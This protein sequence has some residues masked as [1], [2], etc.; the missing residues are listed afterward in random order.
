MNWYLD[1]GDNSDI[2]TSTRIRFA[3]NLSNYR[4]NQKMTKQESENMISEIENIIP[5]LGYG[6]KLLRLKDI[7]DITKLTL[8][9][10][11]LI[12]PEFAFKNK[13]EGAII[14][15]E[16]ENICIMV[17]EEDHLRI[18]IFSSGLNLENL[19]NL[20]IEL[21]EKLSKFLSYATNEKYG[22]LTSCPTNVGTGMRVSV[23]LNLPALSKTKNINKILDIINNFGMNIRGLY[24]ENSKIQGNMY[25]ISNKQA[26]GITEEET[27]KKIKSITEKVIE[28]ERLA[29]S[30]LGKNAL[31]LEDKVY[32]DYGILANARKISS[33]EAINILSNVKLGVHMGIIK[34]ITDLQ[35]KKL[36]LY[37]KPAN[38]QKYFGKILD[39]YERDIKRAELIKIILKE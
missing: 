26:L 28:Q 20:G 7:D 35:I 27:I 17:N 25:Q 22:F 36:E 31:E 9:E 5:S 10:K 30:Y 32:R 3:R 4:F 38:L 14:I 13:L 8:V 24:G 37:I 2:V 11:H 1:T 16:E 34:E 19:I 12:S 21:D 15:N 6:L 23:M 29:R 39:E 18:Q 33:E